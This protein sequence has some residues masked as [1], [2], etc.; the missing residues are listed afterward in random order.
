MGM[1]KR[2]KKYNPVKSLIKSLDELLT[3]FC[4]INVNS[5]DGLCRLSRMD[6]KEVLV[7]EAVHQI[8]TVRRHKWSVYMAGFG[9]NGSERYTK[10][11]I[12]LTPK[13]YLQS[14]LMEV[15]NEHHQRLLK[16]FNQDHLCGF[17]WIAS[18]SGYDFTEE[19]AY[20]LF[21]IYG[22]FRNN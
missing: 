8:L 16:G 10:S 13:P 11:E 6:G 7:T 18:P 20:K 21:D 14:E 19:E 1:K 3:G 12:L 15:L 5:R 22:A 17:G 4:V 2:S 9:I